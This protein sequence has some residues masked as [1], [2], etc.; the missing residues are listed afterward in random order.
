[1][2]SVRSFNIVYKNSNIFKCNPLGAVR[3][4]RSFFLP[5]ISFLF[6]SSS[7]FKYSFHSPLLCSWEFYALHLRLV[8]VAGVKIKSLSLC[9]RLQLSAILPNSSL[10]CKVT[11]CSGAHIVEGNGRQLAVAQFVCFLCSFCTFCVSLC[12]FC[13]QNAYYC[14]T[15]FR[16]FLPSHLGHCR[17]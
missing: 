12:L 11:C 9:F 5:F 3:E 8:F 10:V 2:G 7:D 13:C 14:L 16:A 4:C 17:L 15:C 6:Y 1:M